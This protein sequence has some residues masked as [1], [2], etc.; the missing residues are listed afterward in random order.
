M[1]LHVGRR[2]AAI[3][4]RRVG[5]W[6]R[7]HRSACSS[8]R[9]R[10]VRASTPHPRCG[11]RAPPFRDRLAGRTPRSERGSR[12]SSPCP[13]NSASPLRG[14][15][16]QVRRALVSHTRGCWFESSLAHLPAI[17]RVDDL[18][19]RRQ[20]CG[21]LRGVFRFQTRRRDSD[22]GPAVEAVA[23]PGLTAQPSSSRSCTTATSSGNGTHAESR[24]SEGRKTASG[25][26]ADE[27]IPA[28]GVDALRAREQAAVEGVVPEAR[29]GLLQ[30][31]ADPSRS[32]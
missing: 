6:H 21:Q 13:R 26:L 17:G 20:R 16:A 1:L 30:D 4:G 15:V 19:R 32:K 23:L 28:L 3:Q 27:R 31:V 8:G 25:E 29:C 9:A 24:P 5:E 18:G 22:A 10:A 12:G 7:Q 14:R 11:W 2:S